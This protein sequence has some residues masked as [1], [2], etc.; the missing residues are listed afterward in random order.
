[1]SGVREL[2]PDTEAV[3]LLCGHFDGN[4][5]DTKPL[6]TREYNQ[7]VRWLND[8]G[9]RPSA[10]TD[11]LDSLEC[12]E[13][14][15][16]E[17]ERISRL[18]SRGAALAVNVE[19]WHS[20]SLW[21]IS[22]A[23]PD[24]PK[25]YLDRL[26]SN[27]PPILYGAGDRSLFQ[28]GGLAVVGSR[29]V[30][31]AGIEFTRVVAEKAARDN[32]TIISG[33]ARGVDQTAMT[34]TLEVGGAAVGVLA[35]NLNRAA[36]NAAYRDAIVDQRLVLLTP[37]NPAVGFTVGQAMGR[38]KLIYCLADW[39]LVIDSSVE[40]GGTWAGAIENLR[41]HWVPLFV[42]SGEDIPEG[43]QRL[44]SEGGIPLSD[45]TLT[46]S[47]LIEGLVR[48][49]TNSFMKHEPDRAEV[50]PEDNGGAGSS[51]FDAAWPYIEMHL[52]SPRALKTLKQELGPLIAPKQVEIWLKHA[53][54]LDLVEKLK[55]PVRYRLKQNKPA[56]DSGPAVTQRALEL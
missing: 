55:K 28:E 11:E 54:E 42:R 7:L 12:F 47:S 33:G 4:E 50:R 24:Y 29:N 52:T 5:D 10:L 44:L 1:M 43:N 23:D 39:S 16:L 40:S 35:N 14:T 19:R 46:G 41:K 15:G 45:A 36:V 32:I 26:K 18:L 17:K 31:E 13:G 48:I 30:D 9:F 37:Y 8:Q 27:A 22:R 20:H 53:E 38:N 25:Y 3:L 34:A 6:N 56:R 21:V 49:A 2:S 51:I